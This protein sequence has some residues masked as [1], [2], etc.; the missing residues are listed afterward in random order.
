MAVSESGNAR[1]TTPLT[2]DLL[3]GGRLLRRAFLEAPTR[4]AHRGA[5]VIG[6]GQRDA[7][8]FLIHRGL[9]YSSTTLPDGRRSIT[10]ILLPMDIVGI[11]NVVMGYAPHAVVAANELF[12]RPLDADA[13]RELM[14]NSQVALR[15]LALICEARRR[16]DRHMSG[17][18]RLSA[19]E[20][21]SAFYLGI[22]DR[23]LRREL[24]S[25]PTFN[26]SFTQDEIADHLGLTMVHVSRT[27]RRL[28]EEKLLLVD[29]QVVI[30]LDVEGLTRA[31]GGSSN[32]SATVLR[33]A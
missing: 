12:Y 31:A 4:S 21:L 14:F 32:K 20:R 30:I 11:D 33:R 24:I 5:T 22:Y 7:P 26:A 3:N 1:S 23:L 18:I 2:E 10:D 29:R 25:R 13:V 15:V 19:R 6:P 17:L 28:R 9:A 27:L 16:A 8:A